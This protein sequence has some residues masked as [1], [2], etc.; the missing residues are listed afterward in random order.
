MKIPP[1]R[2]ESFLS[3]LG[4][5]IHGVLLYGPDSGLIRERAKG[6]ADKITGGTDDPFLLAELTAADIREDPARVCDE[7]CALA[8]GGGKRAVRLRGATD[9]TTKAIGNA[10]ESLAETGDP[11]PSLLIVE[12]AE[13]GPRSSLRK[14]FETAEQGAAIPCYLDE[15]A[16][17][18][19]VI[20]DQLLK[21]KLRTDH[22]ALSWLSA[23][24]GA[25]R[26]ITLGELEKLSLYCAG[27]EKV[28]LEDCQAVVGE[29]AA[30]DLDEAVFAAGGGEAQALDQALERAFREGINPITLL[31]AAQRH[32]QRLHQVAGGVAGGT[33]LEAAVKGL[34]PPVFF[35][36]ARRFTAQARNWPPDRL[37]GA[38][39]ILTEAELRCK[40]T[41][42]P[43]H[44]ICQRA[45]MQIA[46][47]GR[48]VRR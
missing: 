20:E 33:S 2:A 23:N 47:A 17:L 42:Q 24:L 38:L 43:D 9:G 35:K 32:F 48:R 31:R 1:A 40:S 10:L 16:G 37:A 11:S 13:L 41:G 36:L 44:L 5:D 18:E 34:R 4:D 30:H 8:F 29:A 14:L 27:A 22:D 21:H 45:L 7:A 15:G 12:A 25:D 28:T 6:M 26:G 19:R 39:D 46:N 3:G